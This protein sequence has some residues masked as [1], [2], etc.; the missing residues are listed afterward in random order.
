MS[1][2]VQIQSYLGQIPPYYDNSGHI[3]DKV[4]NIKNIIGYI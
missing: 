1:H 2:L 4:S 3:K